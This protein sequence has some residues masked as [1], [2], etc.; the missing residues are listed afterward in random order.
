MNLAKL[1]SEV[2]EGLV[3]V[4]HAVGVFALGDSGAFFPVRCHQ[5]ICQLGRGS[6]AF[7]FADGT[8]DP[9]EGQRLLTILVDL[10]RNLVGRTTDPLGSNF[11]VRL[12][13]LD[14]LFENFDR[15]T[16]LDLLSNF[17]E[18]VVEDIVG[19]GLLAVVHQAVDELGDQK[20]VVS[21]IRTEGCT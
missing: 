18:G 21:W 16:V 14:C 17:V 5:F 15:W 2:S 11:D 1:P 6:S 10:H 3:R 4:R 12:N 20:R 19:N 8:E 13:V 9:A 7:L